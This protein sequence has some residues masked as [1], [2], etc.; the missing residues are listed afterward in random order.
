MGLAS[1]VGLQPRRST[2]ETNMTT[3]VP[4]TRDAIFD[5]PNDG[6]RRWIV[7]G[8][9]KDWGFED[10]ESEK[11]GMTI[12]NET[13]C[14]I[15]AEISADLVNW[16][17]AQPNPKGRIVCGE[18]GVRLPGLDST[19]GVDIAYVPPNVPANKDGTTTIIAGLPTLIVEILSPS[20]SL[21]LV[22][23]TVELYM[24]AGVPRVWI[25]S[26]RRRELTVYRPDGQAK[27]YLP[28]DTLTDDLF[29][30]LS[31]PLNR[32]FV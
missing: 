16:N 1:G 17:R 9:V 3:T 23:E 14:E 10:A 32:V 5:L 12:R 11:A 22:D 18:A 25:I 21:E 31:L 8:Q 27:L 19:V 26:P 2:E 7:N 15:M 20:D 28:T 30:G 24:R 13:H 29:P 4:A 6:R